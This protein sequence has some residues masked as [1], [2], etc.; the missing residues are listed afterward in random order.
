[1]QES[2]SLPLM[3]GNI[4]RWMGEVFRL[5]TI[6]APV[7]A[8]VGEYTLTLGIGQQVAPMAKVP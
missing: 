2:F 7:L 5:A 1:M 8:Y 4:W 6:R 3:G